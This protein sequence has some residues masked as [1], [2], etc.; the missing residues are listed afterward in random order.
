[1]MYDVLCYG[2]ICADQRIWLPHLPHLGA[3]VHALDDSLEAGGNA[4]LEAEWLAAWGRR[5]VLMGDRIGADAGGTVVRAALAQSSIDQSYLTYDHDIRTPLCHVLITPGGER[6]M[7]VIRD[8]APPFEPP[9]P[10]LLRACRIIS[11]TRYG[12]HTAEFAASA[13]QAGCLLVA[14]D[15][16]QPSDPWADYADIIVTSART[17][18]DAAPGLPLATQMA[19]LHRRRGAAV[20]VSDGPRPL[21]ALWAA[22]GMLHETSLT[23][24]VITPVD[25]TGAGDVLRA[26]VVHGL[27]AGWDWPRTLHFAAQ[28]AAAACLRQQPGY[29][30]D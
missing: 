7:L 3:G 6:T 20:V 21:R 14:G 23:P 1:M 16:G 11:V 12:P 18:H 26:G 10:A 29:A 22:D 27:L 5:V 9:P 28:H 17:L 4:F 8:P 30:A 13:R 15:V 25:T 2:A 19:A 24:P